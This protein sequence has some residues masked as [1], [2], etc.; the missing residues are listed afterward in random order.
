V[1][2]PLLFSCCVNR[3]Y[4]QIPP[5]VFKNENLKALMLSS[6]GKLTWNISSVICELKFLEILDLSNNGFSG[7]IPQCLGNFSDGL[8]VLHLGANNLHGISLQSIQRVT[9]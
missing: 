8:S 6:N 7:F 1:R 3:L 4:G 2:I 5:S 9:I